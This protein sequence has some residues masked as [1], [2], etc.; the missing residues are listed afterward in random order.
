MVEHDRAS[1][2]VVLEGISGSGKDTRAK[3]LVE[4]IHMQGYN[5]H[6]LTEPN[7][8]RAQIDAY[9]RQAARDPREEMR[10]FAED[11]KIGLE[12]LTSLLEQQ[13]N[14]LV[15]VRSFISS[16]V[17]QS[18]QGVPIDEIATI[19]AFFPTPDLALI[20]LCDPEIAMQRIQRRAEE[21][22]KSISPDEELTKIVR[23]RNRYLEVAQTLPYAHI[24]NTNGRGE[25]IDLVIRS[26]INDLLGIKMKKA[27]FLDKD[28]TLVDN[29]G[30]PEIIPSDAFF[31]WTFPA[32]RTLQSKG[33][34]LFIISSQPWVARG[35]MTEQ[36]V[37]GVFQS[38]SRQCAAQGITIQGYGYCIHSGNI[39]PDKKPSTRLLEKII[40]RYNLD[41]RQSWIIGDDN[42]D[43]QTGQ[44]IGLQTI[45][46]DSGHTQE[47]EGPAIPT[48]R[49]KDLLAAA[50]IV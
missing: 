24:V 41:T 9:K 4:Y 25:A 20:L 31:S 33:Y 49:V 12:N 13:G 43:V 38:V 50:E 42:R 22:G 35:R 26:H 34:E 39:C 37:E 47:R 14:C 29:R 16:L 8:L 5:L 6:L 48:H 32:L 46:V 36:E 11:R 18:L 21:E 15:M 1:R 17:Y 2:L 3:K 40:D 10:L 30:Y 45:M 7:T 23:L 27:I 19:N 28:G 44:N